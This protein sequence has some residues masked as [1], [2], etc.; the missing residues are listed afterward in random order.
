MTEV[1]LKRQKKGAW[2]LGE[3]ECREQ[4]IR[5]EQSMGNPAMENIFEG[6]TIPLSGGRV[7]RCETSAKDEGRSKALKEP[8]E[9]RV[10][11]AGRSEA[12]SQHQIFVSG[13]HQG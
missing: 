8:V 4:S 13:E 12:L 3:I 11:L 1:P 9:I 10:D 2:L 5:R 6:V 7:G